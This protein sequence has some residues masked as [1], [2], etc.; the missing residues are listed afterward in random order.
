MLLSRF[1]KK[2]ASPFRQ[3][4]VRYEKMILP[5]RRIRFG[6]SYFKEDKD[7][8]TSALKEADR[9]IEHCGLTKDS[10][11]VEIG[12]GPGRLPTGIIDRRPGLRSYR[13]IDLNLRSIAW[14][15]KYITSAHPQFTFVHLDIFNSRY[16]KEGTGKQEAIRLPADDQSADIIYL[17]SVFSH[18]KEA[19]V[20][21]N[22]REFA[23]IL[24]KD[25]VLF[26]TA[27]VEPNVPRESENPTDYH[28]PW[29]GPLHCVRFD[30]SFFI[31]LLKE[32]GFEIVREEHGTETD[33]QTALYIKHLP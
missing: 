16:N 8:A 18:L 13:G 6:G 31:D 25:G 11:V 23:R 7:F 30:Q 32:Y 10:S 26:L 14:C 9:L 22:L 1:L 3:N 12:C 28:G 15:Q 24:K 27:F 20:R 29:E 19:D 17:Y 2:I 4:F 21:A 5:P 33:G